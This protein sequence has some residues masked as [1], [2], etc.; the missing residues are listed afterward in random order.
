M[1][2]LNSLWDTHMH[3]LTGREARGRLEGGWREATGMLGG[4]W[5]EGRGRVEFSLWF[6]E[7]LVQGHLEVVRMC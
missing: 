5:R 1:C 4:G 3:G 6:S 2:Y 7:L